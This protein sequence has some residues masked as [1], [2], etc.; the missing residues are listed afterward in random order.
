MSIAAEITMMY[1]FG[2]QGKN[3]STVLFCRAITD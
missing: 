1:G 2:D 3:D